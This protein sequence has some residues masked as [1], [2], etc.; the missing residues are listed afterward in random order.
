VIGW[1]S[2]IGFNRAKRYLLTGE[3]LTGAQAYALGLVTDLADTPEQAIAL[4]RG[5]AERI[6]ALSPLAV[7]G[8]KRA[9]NALATV[10]NGDAQRVAFE[11]E[12]QTLMSDD[13]EEAMNAMAERRAPSFN[14]R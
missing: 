10:R 7:Q 3:A 1:S 6:A 5:L 13:L 12:H 14:N 9:F 4:A 2:A 11:V 8:T